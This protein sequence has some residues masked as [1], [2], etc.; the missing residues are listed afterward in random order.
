[1]IT[2][3]LV[4]KKG[5]GRGGR[6]GISPN[7]SGVGAERKK[8]KAVTNVSSKGGQKINLARPMANGKKKGIGEYEPSRSSK[9]LEIGVLEKGGEKLVLYRGARI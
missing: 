7:T 9:S 8:G 3:T 2:Y 4:G 6:N 1:M 5:R